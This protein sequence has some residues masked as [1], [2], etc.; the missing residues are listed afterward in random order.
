MAMTKLELEITRYGYAYLE[1]LK[2]YDQKLRRIGERL[3]PVGEAKRKPELPITA[4]RR[5]SYVSI[6]GYKDD[7]KELEKKKDSIGEKLGSLAQEHQLW[8]DFLKRVKGI[9]PTLA[10]LLICVSGDIEMVN[11]V[12]GFWKSFGLLVGEDGKI[13]KMEKGQQGTI[14]YGPARKMRGWIRVSI[15]KVGSQHGGFFYDYYTKKFNRYKL[16]RP[17]WD[18]GHCRGAAI[19]KMHKIFLSLCY[20]VWRKARG[21]EFREP[22]ILAIE[23]SPHSHRIRPEDAM[24]MPKKPARLKK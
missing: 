20:E 17:E 13:K 9:G 4:V 8:T 3:P 23:G 21:L 10:G 12:S 14:G 15:F 2:Q 1:V 11:S 24:E 5:E 6:L 16:E 19:V 7:I 22:Y 18:E